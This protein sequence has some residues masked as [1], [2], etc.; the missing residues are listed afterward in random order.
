MRKL[1][2]ILYQPYKW[3]F[4]FPFL[5]I[6]TL[7]FC[8]I[9][10]LISLF[11]QK[12]AGYCGVIWARLNSYLTPISIKVTG[13]EHIQKNTSYIIVLN[14][15]SY[16]DIFLIYG[17]LGI[18]IKW[19]MKQELR[20]IPGFGICCE[21]IGHIFIDRSNTQ[22]AIESMNK[23]K[24]KLVN[25]TSVVIFPEGT[26][27]K[28]GELAPFKR[29]AFR[30]A[31]DLGLPILPI[32]LIG[33]KDILPSDSFNLLPGKAQMIIHE[34]IFVTKYAD[35]EINTLI[36]DVSKVISSALK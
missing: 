1:G 33:T 8:I 21:M 31:M 18:D 35:E 11:S 36:T 24:Q 32:T 6:N 17:W 26:R 5:I 27:S 22:V 30:L 29:G 7:F 16:Y 20:K 2:Y 28:T 10:I 13:K 9:A 14:H 15:Q 3:L 4:F 12:A 23:V 19:V 25:G 34:P